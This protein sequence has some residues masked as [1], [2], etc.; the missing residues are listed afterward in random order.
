MAGDIIVIETAGAS[1]NMVHVFEFKRGSA[2]RLLFENAF[3]QYLHAET[4]YKEVLLYIAGDGPPVVLR[5]A[6]GRD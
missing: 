1:S 3:K 4:S 6:T 5:F 2:P